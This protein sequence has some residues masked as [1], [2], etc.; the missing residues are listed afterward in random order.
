MKSST[1]CASPGRPRLEEEQ[2]EL[3]ETICDLAMFDA[4]AE[5][6]R[7]WE[8]VRT[9][10]ALL[11]VTDKLTELGFNIS[12]SATYIRLLSRRAD[13]RQ[14]KRQVVTVPMK[15]SRPEA[16]HHKARQDQYFSMAS[17]RSLKTVASVH[18]PHS[19]TFYLRMTKPVFP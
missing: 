6:R 9:V 7:R 16:N 5:E 3:L 8:I 19:V 13:T 18:G 10:H 14:A 12:R 15:L 4:F 17:I 1:P 2:S 11:E